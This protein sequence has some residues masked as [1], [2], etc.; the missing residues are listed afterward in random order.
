[1][2]NEDPAE[3]LSNRPYLCTRC[4]FRTYAWPNKHECLNKWPETIE[5]FDAQEARE[6]ANDPRMQKHIDRMNR[7]YGPSKEV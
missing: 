5:D 2:R 4:G 1:M 7:K 6:I 3:D